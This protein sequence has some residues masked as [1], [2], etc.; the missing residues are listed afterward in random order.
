MH[1]L[2]HGLN[3][4]LIMMAFSG[5]FG[6]SSSPSTETTQHS[7]SAQIDPKTPEATTNTENP[8]K[9]ILSKKQQAI[10]LSIELP[11]LAGLI[12]YIVSFTSYLFS[13]PFKRWVDKG[14]GKDPNSW[15]SMLLLTDSWYVGRYKHN[16][17]TFD[18]LKRA[19][20]K[21]GFRGYSID[22]I[23][24]GTQLLY[25]EEAA[26]GKNA[27]QAIRSAIQSNTPLLPIPKT[28]EELVEIWRTNYK[29]DSGL[30]AQALAAIAA[31]LRSHNGGVARFHQLNQSN[32][33][34]VSLLRASLYTI[35]GLIDWRL[36]KSSIG[37]SKRQ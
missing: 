19:V 22:V 14:W 34:D 2:L 7:P 28:P 4:F 29:T 17:G 1:Y 15:T 3:F 24:I 26:L 16:Y 35:V 12:A 36:G 11:V 27:L 31:I 9:R 30:A 37:L 8:K 13:P 25:P 18:Q 23:T 6:S 10:A 20:A 32:P 21:S 33:P 5:C